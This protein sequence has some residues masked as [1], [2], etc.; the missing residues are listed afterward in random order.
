LIAFLKYLAIFI[1]AASGALGLLVDFKKDGKVTKFGWI[2]LAGII[3][4][5]LVSAV[6]QGIEIRNNKEA[7][8]EEEHKTQ[9][10]LHEISRGTYNVDV[11]S[12]SFDFHA[13]VNR[14]NKVFEAYNR[15]IRK[16]VE[17][18]KDPKKKLPVGTYRYDRDLGNGKVVLIGFYIHP[19]SPLFP[20][21][22]SE[23]EV[24]DIFGKIGLDVS[25]YKKDNLDSLTSLTYQNANLWF[26]TQKVKPD[27]TYSIEDSVIEIMAGNVKP[28]P[29]E[30]SFRN[31]GGIE[32]LL[33]LASGAISF[34]ING[35][36][37]L[38]EAGQTVEKNI[39]VYGFSFNV[40]S[41]KF[42]TIQLCKIQAPYPNYY[43]KLPEN[44][45]ETHLNMECRQ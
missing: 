1:T 21:E 10:I 31:H 14:N 32:S 22:K 11:N 25:I 5:F 42:E 12:M 27:L 26:A 3:L 33:D 15:R 41:R 19:E 2:S 44:T 37:D 6:L 43:I 18:Y 35:N 39:D 8:L 36:Q 24:Y 9:N 4:S 16:A 38:D 23:K 7:Q 30:Y 28:I 34:T 17:F 13:K 40:R 29:E 20:N 45:L